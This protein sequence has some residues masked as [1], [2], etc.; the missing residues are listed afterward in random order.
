[1]ISQLPRFA[2]ESKNLFP[3]DISQGMSKNTLQIC[4]LPFIFVWQ[5]LGPPEPAGKGR[6]LLGAVL[7]LQLLQ[8][9]LFK[10][11]G[12]LQDFAAGQQ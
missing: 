8:L 2:Q 4:Q 6:L 11:A 9:E 5:W 3:I 1:M 10:A 7:L 12:I